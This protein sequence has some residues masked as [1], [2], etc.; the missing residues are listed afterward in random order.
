MCYVGGKI[1]PYGFTRR[2]QGRI[3]LDIGRHVKR[4]DGECYDC[5]I[6]LGHEFVFG[7]AFDVEEEVWG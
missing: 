4:A 3:G 7:E 6:A 5:G 1:V 2:V